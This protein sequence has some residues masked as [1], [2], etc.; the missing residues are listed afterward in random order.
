MKKGQCACFDEIGIRSHVKK[1]A[2]L[3]HKQ[4]SK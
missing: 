3:V 1:I 4:I 2:L